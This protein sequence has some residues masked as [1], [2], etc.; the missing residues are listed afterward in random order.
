MATIGSWYIVI[1][2]FLFQQDEYTGFVEF[3]NEFKPYMEV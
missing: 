1:F 3:K 2:N